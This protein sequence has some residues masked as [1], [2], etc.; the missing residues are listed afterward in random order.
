VPFVIWLMRLETPSPW[1]GC[2]GK[3]LQH[4]QVERAL[5]EISLGIIIACVSYRSSV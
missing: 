2:G 4:Q 1:S 3:R 5:E